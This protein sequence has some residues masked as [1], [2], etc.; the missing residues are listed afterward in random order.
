MTH[1]SNLLGQPSNSFKTKPMF[2]PNI[3]F[4][5]VQ[6]AGTDLGFFIKLWSTRLARKRLACTMARFLKPR[7][8]KGS[9]GGIFDTASTP[10]KFKID[11]KHDGLENVSPASNMANLGIYV[12]FLG[13]KCSN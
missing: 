6:V 12:K 8:Q 3:F 11:T 13:C 4:Y 5:I 7:R 1:L 2:F 10:P 9:E